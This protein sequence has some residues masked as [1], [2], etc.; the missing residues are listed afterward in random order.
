MASGHVAGVAAL[1]R[2]RS[3]GATPRSN[4]VPA[5]RA[6]PPGTSCPA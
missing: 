1:C 4:R 2:Q 3:P 6:G 5:R